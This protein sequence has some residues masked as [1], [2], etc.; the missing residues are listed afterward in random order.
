MARLLRLGSRGDDVQYLQ[1]SL[2]QA[3]SLPGRR[4]RYAFLAVDGIFGAMTRSRVLEFQAASQLA[5]DG[6]AGPQTLGAL[7]D[8]LAASP[9]KP[10]PASGGVGSGGDVKGGAGAQKASGGSSAQKASGDSGG[11]KWHG[12]GGTQ[13]FGGSGGIKSLAGSL[14]SGGGGGKV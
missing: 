10:T 4:S 8:L 3:A 11:L 14:K 13:K 2:N 1:A 9:M 5:A 7:S 6:L 12:G